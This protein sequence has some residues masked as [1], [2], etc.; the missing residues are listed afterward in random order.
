[1][2]RSEFLTR[3]LELQRLKS[4]ELANSETLMK[5]EVFN[6]ITRLTNFLNDLQ[7]KA[8]SP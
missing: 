4:A 6:S 3:E 1:M 2:T 5:Y 8:P 7:D